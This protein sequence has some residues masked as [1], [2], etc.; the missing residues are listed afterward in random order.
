MDAGE[1]AV[2]AERVYLVIRHK[3]SPKPYYG[4]KDIRL[5]T[6]A[7]HMRQ[8]LKTGKPE[9]FEILESEVNWKPYSEDA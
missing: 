2:T 4:R 1:M 3:P 6:R 8:F 7:G 9:E 5:Y